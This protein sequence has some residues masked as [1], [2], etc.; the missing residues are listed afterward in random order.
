LAN[1]LVALAFVLFILSLVSCKTRE[2]TTGTASKRNSFYV[3]G[4]FLYAPNGEKVILRGVNN[5]NVVSDKT[6]EKSLPEIEK[7]GANVVRMMWTSWGGYGDKLEVLLRNCIK[8]KMIPLLELHDAT[9]KWELLDSTVAFWLRPDVKNVLIK[10]QQYLLLNIANEAGTAAVTNKDFA[11]KYAVLVK[12][13]REGGLNMPLVID[14]ANWGRNEDYLLAN[15]ETLLNADPLRNLIFS[16]HIWDSGIAEER[17]K[18]AIDRSIGLNINLLIGEFAPME[19]KCKC[20]IPYKYILQYSQQKEIG[21][22][23]WSWGPGNSDCPAMDMTKT[24]SFNTLFDWG[25]EVATTDPNSIK[26]TSVRP[27]HLTKNVVW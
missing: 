8:N 19:V 20:C 2:R 1:C 27:G 7:T 15:A 16:W 9:G 13:L 11:E 12:R 24:V 21:W 22:L 17:I 6:G 18:T 25:L 14:A 26:N 23:A 5:M 3:S 10:Y 4:R